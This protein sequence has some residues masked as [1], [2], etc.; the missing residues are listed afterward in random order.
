[1]AINILQPPTKQATPQPPVTS[2]QEVVET[3]Q[4]DALQHAYSK[5]ILPSRGTDLAEMW[6]RHDFVD[7]FKFALAERI[8]GTL[9]AH[10]EHVQVI[11]YFDPNLNPDAATETYAA[12]DV[13]VNLLVQVKSKSAALQSFIAALDRALTEQV[14]KLPSPLFAS[15]ASILNPILI[16][17]EDVDQRRGYAV[18]LSSLYLKPRQLWQRR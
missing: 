4:I 14:R 11:Y 13:T 5:C 16:T 2:L 10:D 8:A 18:L 9:A 12:L 7:H 1:M 3:I 6:Q 17:Q 15:L